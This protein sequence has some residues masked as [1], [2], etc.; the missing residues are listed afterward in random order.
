MQIYYFTLCKSLPGIFPMCYTEINLYHFKC[1]T[2]VIYSIPVTIT[3]VF[4]WNWRLLIG[5]LLFSST[6]VEVHE[7]NSAWTL[8]RMSIRLEQKIITRRSNGTKKF[9]LIS[10]QKVSRIATSAY[11]TSHIILQSGGPRT[12]PLGIIMER[13]QEIWPRNCLVV[14]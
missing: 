1:E 6:N 13:I 14:E 7:I 8:H 10:K 3:V 11:C 4:L 9:D 5:W 12:D 2:V